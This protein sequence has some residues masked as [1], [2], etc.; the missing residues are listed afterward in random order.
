MQRDEIKD[1]LKKKLDSLKYS[2]HE[3]TNSAN[4]RHTARSERLHLQAAYHT[5]PAVTEVQT[6]L[7]LGELVGVRCDVSL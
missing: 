2:N 4:L 6:Q 5:P 7:L 1:S 3:N